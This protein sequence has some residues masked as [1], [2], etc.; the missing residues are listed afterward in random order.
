MTPTCLCV[1]ETKLVETQLTKSLA[2]VPGYESY[3]AFSKDRK[4]YSGVVT[5]ARERWAPSSASSDC[6]EL[7]EELRREGR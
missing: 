6:L 5:Y 1:Q 4:G 7:E 2:L 3:W